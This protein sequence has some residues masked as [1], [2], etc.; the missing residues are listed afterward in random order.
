MLCIHSAASAGRSCVRLHALLCM[1]HHDGCASGWGSNMCMMARV[2]P[3]RA[4]LLN[5]WCFNGRLLK[6]RPQ[7]SPD[8]TEEEAQAAMRGAS[9]HIRCA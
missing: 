1:R 4:K 6:L 8:M 7:Y 9:I 3:C 5:P 2:A